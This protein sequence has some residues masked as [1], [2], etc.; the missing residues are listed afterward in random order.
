[1]GIL[2]LGWDRPL[3]GGPGPSTWDWWAAAGAL[4]VF[5]LLLTVRRRPPL[6]LAIGLA[7]VLGLVLADLTRAWGVVPVW[8]TLLLVASARNLRRGRGRGR[9]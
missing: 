2:S 7:L 5:L 9:V 6:A 8:G 1:M 3:G 4:A